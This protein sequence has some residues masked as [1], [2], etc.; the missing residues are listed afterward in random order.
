MNSVD[1]MI[2]LL[3]HKR[4]ERERIETETR[5]SQNYLKEVTFRPF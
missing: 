3:K 4:R 2:S 5:T 1:E